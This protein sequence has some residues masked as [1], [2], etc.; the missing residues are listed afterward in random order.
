MYFDELDFGGYSRLTVSD[1]KILLRERGLPIS[2][3]KYILIERL[4]QY[5]DKKKM[6][7]KKTPPKSMIS[8]GVCGT[9]AGLSCKGDTVC[10]GRD[11][12]IMDSGGVCV[13][14]RSPRKRKM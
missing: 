2:G 12:N 8:G 9:I 14:K 4:K 7:P 1:L 5:Q 3:T 6:S 11:P 10:T 13:P